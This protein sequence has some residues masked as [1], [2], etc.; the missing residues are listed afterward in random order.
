MDE[1]TLLYTSRRIASVFPVLH[2]W[3][4]LAAAPELIE[5]VLSLDEDYAEGIAQAPTIERTLREAFPSTKFQIVGAP[6]PG[7]CVK[8][9]N[10][11]AEAATGKVLIALSD[12]FTAFQ[13]WD[14]E[15]KALRGSHEWLQNGKW[16]DGNYVVHVHDG[17]YGDLCTLPVVTK[18]R[19][20][21]TGYFYY[22]GY[23]SMYA[24]TELTYRASNENALIDARYLVFKH[25]H[26]SQGT[27]AEDEV[28]KKH[29]SKN[30][31]AAGELLYNYR[32][33]QG[34]P[35]DRGPLAASYRVASDASIGDT[36][37]VFIQAIRD[38]FC[39]KETC[40]RLVEEGLRKFYFSVPDE[41]WSGTA[42][43]VEHVEQVKE[44]ARFTAN[45]AQGTQCKV[46]VQK[47]AFH[48][49]GAHSRIEVE[50]RCRNQM[51]ERISN[52][53]V[54]HVIVADGDELWIRGHMRKLHDLVAHVAPPAITCRNVPVVG[55]PGYPVNDAKDRVLTYLRGDQRFK[56]C[57]SPWCVA[58]RVE[59]YGLFHFSGVRKDFNE[60]VEKM[61]NSGH[62]DDPAYRFEEFIEKVLPN[63]RPGM[64]NVHMYAGYQIWPSIRYFTPDEVD[65]IPTS[66]HEY[67]DVWA[68]PL[69]SSPAVARRNPESAYA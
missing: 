65:Q 66:I 43:P 13:G 36:Y 37:A 17:L 69:E 10:A 21:Q 53:G 50:T 26:H 56:E 48:R 42:T 32:K 15:L 9:W 2:T 63:I 22:P 25:E 6:V 23:E 20:D 59:D 12:D 54:K 19:Y 58:L 55:L 47:V 68:Q 38:D 5:V 24:D 41:Y 64:Q 51:L 44:A 52:D 49:E 60:I 45:L 62:Y 31:Y 27:R 33:T 14:A 29:N 40:Q 16:M 46:T 11:A 7:N 57:R 3:L 28:D 4:S 67:L 1:F 8:G 34:F 61:R 39:L 18:V 30:R 35:I